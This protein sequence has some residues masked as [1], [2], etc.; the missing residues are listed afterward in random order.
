[1]RISELLGINKSR[2]ELDFYDYEIDRDTYAFLDPYYISKANDSIIKICNDYI[3]SFFDQF[4]LILKVDSDEAFAIFS[5]LGEMNEICL[6]MSKGKPIGKGIGDK[7]RKRV[8]DAI[9]KSDAY[10]NG[11]TDR[12][13]DLRIF[14]EGIDKD[15]I[16]DMV[17]NLIKYPLIQYTQKQCELFGIELEEV[18]SGYYWD[19]NNWSYSYERMIV[20]DGR[21]YLLFPKN[22]ITFSKEYDPKKY[23]RKYVLEKLQQVHIDEDTHLVRKKYD[24]NGKLVSKHVFKKDIE[25]DILISEKTQTIQKNWLSKFSKKYPDIL[26]KF[27]KETISKILVYNEPLSLEEE[28][29]L[30]DTLIKGFGDIPTG[31]DNANKY[32][33]YI[34]GVLELLFYPQIRHPELET[35]I[36][37]GRKRIDIT[38]SN[39]AETGFFFLLGN[40][41]L[42]TC[43]LII[44]ECKNYKDDISNPE[45]DQLAG[46]FSANRGYFGIV[47][48]RDID[49]EELLIKREQDLVRDKNE[50]IFHLTDEDFKNLLTI[51]KNGENIDDY[52]LDK[53]R[54]ILNS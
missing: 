30:I 50:Y 11:L 3:E 54:K 16:S 34:C 8:F 38:Y 48:C 41:Y 32:Q 6:G 27:K 35:E 25:E 44:V 28:N 19:K 39:S 4:L 2:S 45:I 43:P 37:E 14:V 29:E 9:L 51:K 24:K 12:L 47:C 10:K 33:R 15:K 21:K 26:K 53:F 23:L 1:M 5:H 52:L 7:D 31:N 20:K 36:N 17:A 42:I 22:I 18:E 49:N 46:R 13:E 40:S